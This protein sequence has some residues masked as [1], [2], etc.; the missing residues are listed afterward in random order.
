MNFTPVF[1]NTSWFKMR[2]PHTLGILLD[3][4][5]PA[6]K[7]F[8]T[9][10]HS[11]F[12]WWE[13]LDKAQPMH[14]EDFPKN[15]RPLV[16]PIDTW[17]LNRRLALIFEARVGKG[18]LLVSSANLSP[19]Q[20]D[21]AV[22][23]AASQLYYSLQKYML[24]AYFHPAATVGFDVIKDLFTTGS[25]FTPPS[26]HPP[27]DRHALVSRHNPINEKADPLSSLSV[28]NGRFAFTVDITGMQSFPEAYD[29]G[30][31]LGT[32][33]QWGWHSFPDTAGYRF[34][35]TL[36][37]YHIHDRDITY[38]VQLK[39]HAVDYFRENPHR[40]QLGN[41]G[42]ELK[43]NDGSLATLADLHDIHQELILWTGEIKTHFT[44]EGVPVDVSTVA[45]P[46]CDQVAFN[47]HSPLIKM[48]RLQ[49]RV[50]FPYPTGAFTDVGDNW[51]HESLHQ[52]RLINSTDTGVLIRHDLDTTHYFTS[53]AWTRASI[54][55]KQAHYFLISPAPADSFAL[56]CRFTEV[57]AP[58]IPWS[59]TRSASRAAWLDYWQT[60]AAVDFT[61]STDP[62]APELE[63]RIILSQYL[64]R[65]QDAGDDPPQET[66]LTYNSWYGK[67][68]L[69]M[70][71]WH[72]A[73]FALW[74][75]PQLLERSLAWYKK[76]ADG[77]KAIATRQG[78]DGVRWQKMTDPQGHESPSS[79]GAFLIWQQPHLIYMAELCLRAEKQRSAKKADSLLKEYAPLVFATA[80][81]MASYAY[82]DSA[83]H[84]YMLG[85][86]LI[87]AQER[88]KEDSTFNP[89]F[90][91]AYWRWALTIA[92]QW[93][94]RLSLPPNPVWQQVATQL[95]ALPQL[96]APT[97]LSG[98]PQIA[99]LPRQDSLYSPT[100]SATD[101]Y[102]NPRYYG[103]HPAVLATLGFLPATDGLD[104]ARMHQTFDWIEANWDWESTWGWDY[105]LMAMS[106][107]RLGLP[108][109]AIDALL[110]PVKKNTY[111]PDGHN[112]QDDRLRLY[113]PGNG[114]LLS[115]IALMCAGYDGC[116]R[117]NP[118]I[119]QDGKWKVSWEGLN[120][121]P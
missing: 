6:F 41:I 49:V 9:S 73:H 67:P 62:R 102:T 29:K 109:K 57:P 26:S 22:R 76:V 82:Y 38:S 5:N 106:A 117:P 23:P 121:M 12:Q 78:Y 100:E 116:T 47:I 46:D 35:Q 37:S 66:G 86:G 33:S 77:A 65:I 43:K 31:P 44:L 30:I 20:P 19:D 70:H 53:L 42:L 83:T 90:E 93:R 81:F 7:D 17:F 110:M 105:P 14:L 11:D 27:I 97:Q 51:T 50:R 8:P 61:G 63:R 2:P 40:L 95:S 54:A 71:W 91:L 3:P 1:W 88:F 56:A 60:A 58:S 89:C 96:P 18:R 52:T 28:G 32:Q 13:I 59:T 104:T 108:D 115:A 34:D 55:Q 114:G 99:A 107:T 118:G 87:P 72:A 36:K 74:G 94:A 111:L 21:Q 15:F 69:E 112:Y 98:Q 24:S 119:P 48:Q 101:A 79:V 120:P 68:H 80:D 45:Q 39:N 85:P 4:A 10:Y 103:D 25:R 92:Q 84:R 16:Q 113:L 75:H 64:T